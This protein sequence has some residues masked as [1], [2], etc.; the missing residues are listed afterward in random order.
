MK[1]IL[2]LG[3][4]CAMSVS[5]ASSVGSGERKEV[6][7]GIQIFDHKLF[8][9][10]V[11]RLPR[12]NIIISSLSAHMNLAMLSYA[13]GG[14]TATEMR[15]GLELPRKPTRYALR[16][17]KKIVADQQKVENI[18][19]NVVNQIYVD[20]EVK[21]KFKDLTKKVFQSKISQLNMGEPNEA[22]R[23]VNNWVKNATN[24]MI[25]KM[26]EPDEISSD[27]RL[28]LLNAVYFNGS[29][30]EK[31]TA[32]PDMMFYMDDGQEPVTAMT[33]A[34]DL[35]YGKIPNANASFVAIPYKN[36][37]L[38]MVVVVPEQVNGIDN[39]V[40]SLNRVNI[41][42][43]LA[44]ASLQPVNLRIPKF[45]IESEIDL[46]EELPQL[47]MTDMFKD[48]ANFSAL[49]SG[50]LKVDQVRQKAIVGIDENGTKAAAVTGSSLV[51]RIGI[52]DDETLTPVTVDRPFFFTILMGDIPLF[53]GLVRNPCP[54]CAK[55]SLENKESGPIHEESTT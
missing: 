30:E 16:G 22:A 37:N 23:I 35:K 12:E 9:A 5:R 55:T 39:V 3:F 42:S 26:V 51:S 14:R 45:K 44:K 43:L 25:P 34:N 38:K 20:F 32:A 48:T 2:I 29:W 4:A 6:A 19:L 10:T 8:N 13:A 49:G 54:T 36:K 1:L 47:G 21:S 24:D 28:I 46:Q 17:Y 15:R 41:S 52:M 50:S 11:K 31:F 18:T 40:E 27:T 7:R 53:T 33:L